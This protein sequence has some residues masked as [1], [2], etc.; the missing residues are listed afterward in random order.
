L[1][2]TYE[3]PE[4]PGEVVIKVAA[5][6]HDKDIEGSPFTIK[7][8][9]FTFRFDYNPASSYFEESLDG[10]VEY[11]VVDLAQH[12]LTLAAE[13][14]RRFPVSRIA[15]ELKEQYFASE[16][17]SLAA[18]NAAASSMIDELRRQYDDRLSSEAPIELE[19]IPPAELTRVIRAAVQRNGCSE[20]EAKQ[21]VREGRFAGFVSVPFLQELVRR[22][23]SLV[24]DGQFFSRPYAQVG[25]DLQPVILD[26][27]LD[28]L[29]DIIWL[30]DEGAS[31]VSK[32]TGWRLRYSRALSS[33]K[34][35]QFWRA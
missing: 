2:G 12:F 35:L 7:P 5:Y 16:S 29:Q 34:L 20:A 3:V 10:P 9:G 15:R 24:M 25:T 11:M 32:D 19:S 31:A 18:A 28:S 8:E 27:L 30:A 23:P 21:L 22:H 1:S 26:E 33:L 17:A 14:P 13:T 4:L 6:R